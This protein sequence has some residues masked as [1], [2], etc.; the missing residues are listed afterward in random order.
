MHVA[1]STWTQGVCRNYKRCAARLSSSDL[2]YLQ[3]CHVC[4][5]KKCPCYQG[6]A[7]PFDGQ[8]ADCVRNKR[9]PYEKNEFFEE[10]CSASQFIQ[11]GDLVDWKSEYDQAKL[12]MKNMRFADVRHLE[13]CIL[14]MKMLRASQLY[15]NHLVETA[16][17]VDASDYTQTTCV[18]DSV[19]VLFSKM[20]ISEKTDYMR[21]VHEFQS[22]VHNRLVFG[23][24]EKYTL[25][26]QHKTYRVTFARNDLHI[27]KH[28]LPA[29]LLGR[30][31]LNVWLS[32][33]K[34]AQA[35]PLAHEAAPPGCPRRI[36][37]TLISLTDEEVQLLEKTDQIGILPQTCWGSCART[38]VFRG[39]FV[40]DVRN[41]LMVKFKDVVFLNFDGMLQYVQDVMPQTTEFYLKGD[42]NTDDADALM[43]EQQHL[44]FI[45]EF[46]QEED[47]VSMPRRGV[48]DPD[49]D[50]IR[51]ELKFW[52]N[53]TDVG[54][55]QAPQVP[56][57]KRKLKLML[58]HALKKKKES[59]F[60]RESKRFHL[61]LILTILKYNFKNLLLTRGQGLY[62]FIHA[63]HWT[64]APLFF[65]SIP[66]CS[67]S[68]HCGKVYEYGTQK[69]CEDTVRT[70]LETRRVLQFRYLCSHQERL[71]L[72]RWDH[73]NRFEK[74]HVFSELVLTSSEFRYNWSQL[75]LDALRFRFYKLFKTPPKLRHPFKIII[76]K[77]EFDDVDTIPHDQ[78]TYDKRTPIES[79]VF[80]FDSFSGIDAAD[81]SS[82]LYSLLFSDQCLYTNVEKNIP[83]G[84]SLQTSAHGAL[85]YRK[86]I[87]AKLIQPW[88]WTRLE[89]ELNFM[90]AHDE[91]IE[92]TSDKYTEL[93]R[94]LCF[95]K[96]HIVSEHDFVRFDRLEL[97]LHCCACKL[98]GFAPS[99]SYRVLSRKKRQVETDGFCTLPFTMTK[100][101][102]TNTQ[103]LLETCHFFDSRKHFL[104]TTP[105]YGYKYKVWS[106]AW[107][108]DPDNLSL[109]MY[110]LSFAQKKRERLQFDCGQ[111]ILAQPHMDIVHATRGSVEY[112]Y[113]NC[114]GNC[115]EK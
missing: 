21:Q 76:F 108:D 3:F 43:R 103:T 31:F 27:L 79:S 33:E 78:R 74:F 65:S 2:Q 82:N 99:R 25:A 62:F 110:A 107:G 52:W 37:Y 105:G 104:V 101:R 109:E 87:F 115:G 66:H 86:P 38:C 97:M 56:E 54:L 113:C 75:Q 9:Q 111:V 112:K 22:K 69:N 96:N 83:F 59:Q 16:E 80:F 89:D 49:D 28:L 72:D 94:H 1:V 30:S 68:D 106:S 4:C 6:H 77:N 35:P 57:Q 61:I 34:D 70:W 5:E 73:L 20:N 36:R 11:P 50:E 64:G 47:S 48:R 85:Q 12:E 10:R 71:T 14:L 90:I 17:K 23:S 29:S 44:D 58:T 100:E 81:S 60:E 51:R 18:N 98:L 67:V 92:T 24:V 7:C 93:H 114:Y 19:A 88:I 63:Q 42:L 53:E 46:A 102:S 95:V 26:F 13:T 45:A 15:H 40:N 8:C 32:T 84:I 41:P 91:L 39:E 55:M